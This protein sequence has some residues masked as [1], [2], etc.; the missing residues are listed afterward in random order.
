MSRVVADMARM[1][2]LL[3]TCYH[4]GSFGTSISPKG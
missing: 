4:R 1:D 2:Y 3:G